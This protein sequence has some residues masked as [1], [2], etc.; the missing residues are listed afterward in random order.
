MTRQSYEEAKN[1]LKQIEKLKNERD[2]IVNQI[3]E[4][5]ALRLEKNQLNGEPADPVTHVVL[6]MSTAVCPPK[7]VVKLDLWEK[8]LRTELDRVD[9]EIADIEHEFEAL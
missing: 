4:A 3:S 7:V 9:N 5:V 6:Y 8:F 2:L 1:L